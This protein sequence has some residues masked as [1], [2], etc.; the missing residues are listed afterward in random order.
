M[1]TA[2][3]KFQKNTIGVSLENGYFS[4][5]GQTG[6]NISSYGG[7]LTLAFWRKGE[8][9]QNNINKFIFNINQSIFLMKVLGFIVNQR[10]AEYKAGGS[11]AYTDITNYSFTITGFSN[12]QNVTFGA[13]RFDTVDIDGIKRVKMSVTKDNFETS[14]V[15][16]D[17]FMTNIIP[18]G[19]KIQMNYDVFDTS[20]MRFFSDLNGY[21]NFAWQNGAFAKIFNAVA[22]KGGSRGNGGGSYQSSAAPSNNRYEKNNDEIFDTDSDF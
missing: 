13:I 21:T 16:S 14:I 11:E 7:F 5:D 20:L 15:F 10:N 4:Y 1:S 19:S 2:P 12:G 22:G 8:S 17:K 3:T 9:S 6:F 18:E